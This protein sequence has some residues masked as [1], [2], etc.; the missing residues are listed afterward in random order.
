LSGKPVQVKTNLID[1]MSSEGRG[2]FAIFSVSFSNARLKRSERLW[3]TRIQVHV[4]TW[5]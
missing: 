2:V 3:F 5:C 1:F 4:L